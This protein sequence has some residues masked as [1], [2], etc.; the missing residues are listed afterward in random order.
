MI[1]LNVSSNFNK[2]A[3]QLRDQARKQIPFV[4]A[5]TLTDLA[6]EV[7]LEVRKEIPKRFTLRRKWVVNGIRIQS[8]SK[9][10]LEA[11]VYSKDLFMGKQETGGIKH[12]GE[13]KVWRVGNK[14]AI[15]TPFA[16]G[17]TKSGVVPKRNWPENLVNPFQ[18][19][20]K[21]GR[22]Y[23]AIRRHGKLVIMYVL[24]GKIT[25]KDRLGMQVIGQRVVDRRFNKIFGS[26]LS[27]ALATSK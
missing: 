1:S 13:T 6:K 5:K 26:N 15:P 8:A 7:Q 3:A 10:K 12:P 16:K 25:M 14:I 27:R 22:H 18:I 9:R 19:H 17:G 2:I 21:D 23:L 11:V 20:A 4:L 24:E